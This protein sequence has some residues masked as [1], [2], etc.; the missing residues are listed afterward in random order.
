MRAKSSFGLL[1]AISVALS[2]TAHFAYAQDDANPLISKVF[3]TPADLLGP[4]IHKI[5]LAV[6]LF[7]DA[8]GED[9]SGDLSRK[10]A[11]SLTTDMEM[12]GEFEVID[13]ARYLEDPRSAGV[14]LGVFDMHDWSL[15]GAEYLIKGA[16]RRVGDAITLEMR[17]FNVTKNSMVIGKEYK[18]PLEDR[19]K[20]I[21]LFSNDVFLALFGDEGFFGTQIAFTA[22]TDKRREVYIMDLDGRNRRK[23][24]NLGL[25]SMTP[26]WSP[27]GKTIVFSAVGPNTEPS[28]Y[29]INVASG[30]VQMIYQA[31]TGVALTPEFSP[32]GTRIVVTLSPGESS[33]IYEMTLD[34]KN[35][36]KLTDHWAIELAPAYSH[37]GQ[38]MLMISDRTGAPQVYRMNADGTDPVRIS[39]FGSYNQSPNWSPRG[40]KIAYAAREFG[41]YTIYLVN[42]DGGE[43]YALTADMTKED[44]E[45][46]S[47][48]PD[49]RALLFSCKTPAGRALFLRTTND[50]YTM[51]LTKGTS[52]ETNPDWGPL[53]K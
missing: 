41:H 15:I 46:P 37:D 9:G 17:L 38:K 1:F 12:S 19:Y 26:H 53:L 36:T 24:T 45:Y 8:L 43:P 3:L 34:G 40:D 22:G 20:M 11:D 33:D 39:Y 23:M 10:L 42:E 52:I 13:R 6:P 25:L 16:F 27:D 31:Q 2:L 14:K 18:G 29:T 7:F 48:S 30:K 49:G 44:C 4:Q 21:H 28:V 51:Q 32:S 50:T 5:P 47:F 35:L